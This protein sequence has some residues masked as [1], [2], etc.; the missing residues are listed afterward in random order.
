[1]YHGI[2]YKLFGLLVPVI[3]INKKDY[4]DN[5]RAN[6]NQHG[7]AIMGVGTIGQNRCAGQPQKSSYDGKN[8]P[9]FEQIENIQYVQDSKYVANYQGGFDICG[10]AARHFGKSGKNIEIRL[11]VTT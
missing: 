3:W 7:F 9:I 8:V 1:M 5:G 2:D 11:L 10:T 6:V 4:H